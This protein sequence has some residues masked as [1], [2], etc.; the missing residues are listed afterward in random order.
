M[1]MPKTVFAIIRRNPVRLQI[2][3]LKVILPFFSAFV[4]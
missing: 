3:V 1:S 2:K 4:S